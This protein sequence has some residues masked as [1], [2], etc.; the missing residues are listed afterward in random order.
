VYGDSFSLPEHPSADHIL[1]PG[2]IRAR[3]GVAV[4]VILVVVGLIAMGVDYYV[5]MG[6]A[7]GA[8]LVAAEVAR[9]V[10]G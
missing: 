9:R 3:A 7:F 1:R 5:A 2:Q 10:C 6:V 8:G 4:I